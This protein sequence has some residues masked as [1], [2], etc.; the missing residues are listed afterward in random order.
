SLVIQLIAGLLHALGSVFADGYRFALDLVTREQRENP[1]RSTF[2]DENSLGL[3]LHHNREPPPL[4]IERNLVAFRA[5]VDLWRRLTEDDIVEWTADTGL[6]LAVEIS[7]FQC[8]L[9]Y[10]PKG[11]E[12]AIQRHCSSGERSRFI[13]AKHI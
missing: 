7:E 13:A 9:G 2:R 10:F 3:P 6:E 11:I 12:R 5:I 1:L 8:A 4:E